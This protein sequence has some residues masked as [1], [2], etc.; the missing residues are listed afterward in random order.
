MKLSPGTYA[1]LG[2][3][4][5]F[6]AIGGVC[7]KADWSHSW[8]ITPIQPQFLLFSSQYNGDWNRKPISWKTQVGLGLELW[9]IQSV[10]SE[11]ASSSSCG[12]GGVFYIWGDQDSFSDLTCMS[13]SQSR[14]LGKL[15]P[16]SIRSSSA[17]GP[18]CYS[19][20][21]PVPFWV[22]KNMPCYFPLGFASGLCGW[23]K[24]VLT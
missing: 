1:K 5:G 18:H 16:D 17:Q 8:T 20:P 11:S 9:F 4:R 14:Q 24:L 13:R 3:S 7:K 21:A 10:H 22:A 15:L 12:G 23:E 6:Q 19:D 2:W